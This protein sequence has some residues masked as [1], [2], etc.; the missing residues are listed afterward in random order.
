MVSGDLDEVEVATVYAPSSVGPYLWHEFDIREVERDLDRI[1][2]ARIRTVRVALTWDAFMPTDRRVNPRR[3]R[4]LESLLSAAR[5]RSLRVVPVLFVVSLGDCVM[6][7]AWAVDARAPRRGVRVLTEG[8]VAGGGP[9]NVW[10]DPL[11]QEAAVRW[12]DAVLAA[13]AGHPAVAAWDLGHD[14]AS[15]VRPRRI[16]DVVTWLELLGPRVREHGEAVRLTLGEKDITVARAMRPHLI[17]P[18]L[19]RLGLAVR[20]GALPLGADAD[21]AEAVAFLFWVLRRLTT[22]IVPL[23]VELEVPVLSAHDDVPRPEGVL[24]DG[25][26]AAR[27]L[28]ATLRRLIEAGACGLMSAAWG[29]AGARVRSAPPCDRDAARAHAGIVDSTGEFKSAAESWRRLAQA[30]PGALQG[31]D[32]PAL[33]EVEDWYANLPESLLESFASWQ[34]GRGEG[35]AIL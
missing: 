1:A 4:E 13:F 16:A 24:D 20:H 5:S 17:A 27:G 32:R 19:D 29:D 9:R 25:P 6:L 11:M 26:E 30:P 2:G 18:H 28:D 22:D 15:T 31:T 14:P 21:P 7:P 35:D 8:R 34:G 12:L 10:A 33:L 23:H 3:M